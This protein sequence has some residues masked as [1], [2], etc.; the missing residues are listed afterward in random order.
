MGLY[1]WVLLLALSIVWGGSFFFAEIALRE[2]G[3][4]TIVTARV[5]IGALALFVYLR[6]I[7][8]HLPREPSV[9]AQLLIMGAINNAIPFSLL[10]WAQIYLTSGEAAI[11]N[12]AV[13]LFTVLLA[14]W[15]TD[16]ETMSA[17]KLIGV[18]VGIIGVAFLIGPQAVRGLGANLFAQLAVIAATISYALASIYGRRLRS[19]S[20]SVAATGMLTGSTVLLVPLMLIFESPFS[21]VPEIDT[22]GALI[23]LGVL[24]SSIAYLLYFRILAIAGSTN[25]MLVTLL[26]PVSALVLGVWILKE[27]IAAQAYLGMCIIFTGLLVIDGRPVKAIVDIARQLRS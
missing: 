13:P 16:D 21:H 9:L 17:N 20:T 4:L 27:E 5:S 19:L 12:A 2:L 22:I 3:P 11:L 24:S 7:G 23:G 25:L 6:A 15:L 26:V 8:E 18:V 10:V 1:A 14:H